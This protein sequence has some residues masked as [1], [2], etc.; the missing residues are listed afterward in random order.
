MRA[1]RNRD[2]ESAIF[3]VD[4]FD[5]ITFLVVDDIEAAVAKN[6]SGFMNAVAQYVVDVLLGVFLRRGHVRD[7]RFGDA[8]PI[9]IPALV[10]VADFDDVALGQIFGAIFVRRNGDVDNLGVSAELAGMVKLAEFGFDSDVFY[11]EVS[12]TAQTGDGRLQN[13]FGFAELLSGVRTSSCATV[14]TG[15]ASATIAAKTNA[16]KIRVMNDVGMANLSDD[17][18]RRA[19]SR[20]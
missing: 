7:R 8:A 2:A 16:A 13:L 19:P 6:H 20:R 5:P 12:G 18:I 17:F 15:A 4:Q 9:Q 10:A 14:R 1:A 3:A 11:V